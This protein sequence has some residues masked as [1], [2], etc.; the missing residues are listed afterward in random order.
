MAKPPKRIDPEAQLA[1][2]MRELM[3]YAAFRRFLFTMMG[4]SGISSVAYGSEVATSYSEGR[5]SLGIEMLRL[6]DETL[7]VKTT[8]G[9]PFAAM[10]FITN[11][12]LRSQPQ[13]QTDHDQDDEDFSIERR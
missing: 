9:F 1:A 10:A 13:E 4:R 8:D 2:D 7:S 11:E 3:G 12:A 6:A 5:R